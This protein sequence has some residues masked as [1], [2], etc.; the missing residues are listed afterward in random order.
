MNGNAK[1]PTK[2]ILYS[3]RGR[4][5]H[6]DAMIGVITRIESQSFRDAI[7]YA[8]LPRQ[9]LTPNTYGYLLVN[10][11]GVCRHRQRFDLNDPNQRELSRQY[12][13]ELA[14]LSHMEQ[15]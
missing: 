15:A 8:G 1:T 5:E 14:Q 4:T 2:A 3:V 6:G 7:G 12:H 11:S 9:D 13:D 10:D